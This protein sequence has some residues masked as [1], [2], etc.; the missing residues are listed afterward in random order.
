[1]L[2]E[3]FTQGGQTQL[4]KFRMI[5]QV[6]AATFK[7][8]LGIFLL[9]FSLL[10]YIEHP[11]QDF[12][13][14]GVYAKAYF[15]ANCP[16]TISSLSP[17]SIIYHVGD[18]QGHSV[19][20]YTILHSEVVLRMLDYISLSLIKKLLQSVLIAIVGSVL[21]SWFWVR[22]GRK[23]Q[24]TKV[25]SGFECVEP[26]VLRKQ[27]LKYGTSS[28]TIGNIPLPKNAEFQHMMIT[29]TT[30]SGK[31]NMIHQLLK[32]I[33]EKGDQAI[34]IDT[35]GG[36]FAR[37]FDEK[38]DILLNPLDERSSKWDMWSEVTSDYIL[39]ELAE[40]MIPENK[41][42]D[43]FW[44]QSAR[45]V[46][47]ES[48]RFLKQNNQCSYQELIDMTLHLSLK[49]LKERLNGTAVASIVDL[50]I[51]K[52]A[53]SVRASLASNLR[54]FQVLED[55]I[56][57]EEKDDQ[58][59]NISLL[60]FLKYN[61]KTWTFLSCQPDQ[62]EF[63]KPLFSAW[64]SLMIKGIMQRSEGEG[65]RTWIIIDELASLNCL[66]SLMLGLS[67]IRKYGGCFVLGFQ[68]L[69][70]L[71]EIYGQAKTKSLSN[72]TGTKVLFRNVDAEVAARV[73]KYLGEQEKQEASESISFGAHQ[74]R[75][76]VSLSN[77]KQT[78]P[79]V[80]SSQIMMLKDLEAYLKFPGVLPVS[81]I[82]LP[83][84]KLNYGTPV[85]IQKKSKKEKQ[86]QEQEQEQEVKEQVVEAHAAAEQ[87]SIGVDPLF[88]DLTP[89][90]NKPLIL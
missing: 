87:P 33:R 47:C 52:T 28:Y 85:F 48:V 22:M 70:Q 45:Q 6:I 14:V 80:S 58:G 20:D 7:V 64:I 35:T 72:L 1:M 74:M 76:G 4:H 86:K 25:L 62:R 11:W 15:M 10:V 39:D 57:T 31:S 34:V 42:F 8:S 89:E 78:K 9:S 82:A 2:G 53:L 60:R 43:S 30:G 59:E 81:K 61:N 84:L 32:Q 77:Q 71:E 27:I 54:S 13:L 67:E 75:D 12:W 65:G 36:I 18:P 26:K 16:S 88:S 40:A 41:S 69:N 29:G 37:F 79:V 83:Y 46:F 24:E 68:D 55:A 50:A 21:V 23:K 90:K 38:T 66:P 49:A 51:D 19:S 63:L 5:K 44:T 3:F 56:K 17:S 73:A